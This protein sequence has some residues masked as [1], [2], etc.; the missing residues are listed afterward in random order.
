MAAVPELDSAVARAFEAFPPTIR[1]KLLALRQLI[2]E[3]AG[4]TEGVGPITET[5]KWGEPA[6]LTAASG[7]GT[8]IRIGWKAAAPTRYAMYLHC[9][10]SLVDRFRTLVPNELQFEGNRAIV[11]DESERL[12]RKPL[13]MCIAMALTYHR[14]KRS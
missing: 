4:S 9:R 2:F 12:P 1:P 3:V 5:L 13:S 14:S 11:F 10:T 7:S 8:T 6:Y